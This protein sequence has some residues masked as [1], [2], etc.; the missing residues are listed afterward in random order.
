[1]VVQTHISAYKGKT[2]AVDTYSW[3]HKAC[4][5]CA[6]ELCQNIET[7]VYVKFC[8][9]RVQLLVSHGVIP[10]MVF[11]GRYLPAKEA[12]EKQRAASRS[13]NLLQA[14]KLMKIGNLSGADKLF[15]KCV[16]VT[17]AMAHRFIRALRKSNIS[18][19]VAPY[20][21]DAQLAYLANQGYAHA[22]ITEDSDL[23]TFGVKEVLLKMD[24]TGACQ[25]LRMSR[26]NLLRTINLQSFTHEMF[27]MM[28][29][30]SGCDYL[31]SLR[32]MGLKTSYKVVEAH[33]TEE[34]I[35]NSLSQT[36]Q[37]FS[38]DY[39]QSFHQAVLTFK[40]QTV[41]C[42]K[43]KKLVPLNPYPQGQ[44]NADFAFA[45]PFFDDQVA[46]KTIEHGNVTNA[47]SFASSPATADKFHF[48]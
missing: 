26:V 42:P 29:V 34:S 46:F 38:P 45:G 27:V 12:K 22:V 17:P 24:K 2:V 18:Y 33:K 28:C 44:T 15:Q 48:N 6:A 7:D 39:R 14:Q 20:E 21:A 4:C 16:D 3:L 10:L 25:S 31:A 43:L 13:Y 36:H 35:L 40:H 11:D 23:L 47:L 30:L 32:G 8:M 37:N 9:T 5:A 1:M 19:I 41:F